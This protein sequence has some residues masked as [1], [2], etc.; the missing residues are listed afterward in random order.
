VAPGRATTVRLL[1]HPLAWIVALG[2]V[3]VVPRHVVPA[4]VPDPRLEP[5]SRRDTL[6][7]ALHGMSGTPSLDGLREIIRRTYPGADVIAPL[8]VWNPLSNADP[9]VLADVVEQTIH[10]AYEERGYQ[11][12]VLIGHSMGAVI[13]RKVLVWAHG[14]DDDR[15]SRPG[16]RAWASR[17]DR[18]VSL[19]GINRGWSIDPAPAHMAWHRYVAIALAERIGRLTGTGTLVRSMQRGAPFVAD[20]RVQ[21]IRAARGAPRPR[22]GSL[23][24]VVQLVGSIDDIVSADDSRDLAA[25]KDVRFVT[26]PNVGHAEIAQALLEGSGHHPIV[27]QRIEA[28]LTSPEHEIVT[29]TPSRLAEDREVRRVVYIMHGIRDYAAWSDHLRSELVRQLPG[30]ER[31]HV[32]IVPAKY[33]YFPMIP[34][35]LAWDRQRNVRWFMDEFTET[36]ARFPS[37]TEFDYVGHSNGTYILASALQRYRTLAVRNVYFAG[38]V[39][40]RYYPWRPLLD[41]GRVR[42]VNNVVATGDWVVALFP[43]FFEQI[44]DWLG[45]RRATGFLDIGSAGFRGFEASQDPRDRVRNLTYVAGGHGAAIDVSDQQKVRA[46]V[47][48]MATGDRAHLGALQDAEA[49]VGWLSVLSNVSWIVWVLLAGALVALGVPLHLLRDRTIRIGRRRVR[50]GRLPLVAYVAIVLGLLYSV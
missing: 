30:A 40:P 28:A 17:V 44:A 20:L 19:A 37:A 5:G 12:I 9:Y 38:S 11:R 26:I 32:A 2:L 34:F 43:R 31:S 50:L 27:R 23:P 39:V 24:L 25:A 4:R 35:L 47:R 46:I 18:F 41:A 6:V 3:I 7:V 8:Y 15:P 10:A 45:A 36:L 14:F 1:R 21:W 22:A 29:D 33:G 48:Y 49:Q 16:D 13:L 42:E